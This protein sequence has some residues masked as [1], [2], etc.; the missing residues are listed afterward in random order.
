LQVRRSKIKAPIR[1]VPLSEK[2]KTILKARINRFD[3]NF[4]FPHNEKDGAEPVK[5]VG[6]N[7]RGIIAKLD[8][9][10]RLYDCRATRSR[11]GRSK[12]ASIC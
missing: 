3:G 7:H 9:K 5:D 11:R 6:Y 12:A 4:L 8:F 2:A 10:F 1:R